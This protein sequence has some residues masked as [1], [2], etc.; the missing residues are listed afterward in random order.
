[1][2]HAWEIR[3][4]YKILVE[5]R[6]G[7]KPFRRHRNKWKDNIKTGLTDRVLGCRLNSSSSR[8]KPIS[9]SSEYGNQ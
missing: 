3:Y 9:G 5:E 2:Y 7:K 8:E 4:A 1:M 6:E